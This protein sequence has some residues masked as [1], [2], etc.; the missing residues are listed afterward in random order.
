M[1]RSSASPS[2]ASR[3]WPNWSSMLFLARSFRAS[4]SFAAAHLQVDGEVEDG[5]GV[6]IVEC[7][8]EFRAGKDDS[9]LG[10]WRPPAGWPDSCRGVAAGSRAALSATTA[11]S[12]AGG[13]AGHRRRIALQAKSSSW[14]SCAGEWCGV[15]A[16]PV[17]C[18]QNHSIIAGVTGAGE[19][20]SGS[21]EVMSSA[22]RR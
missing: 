13:G 16:A 21:A 6:E 8:E 12:G 22:R 5:A 7:I 14:S 4:S 17:L 20:S 18:R 9:L 1:V 2:R 15:G 10:V 11:A 19:N 3:R